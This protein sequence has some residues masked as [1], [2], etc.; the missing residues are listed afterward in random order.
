MSD[1]IILPV[2][3]PYAACPGRC[4][5]CNQSLSG[6]PTL[7]VSSDEIE[8]AVQTVLRSRT[9]QSKNVELAFY[10]GSFAGLPGAIRTQYLSSVTDLR[11]RGMIAG[12]RAS[13]RPDHIDDAIAAEFH[14]AGISLIE[15]G[16]PSLD[17]EVLSRTGRLHDAHAVTTALEACRRHGLS[18]G[19]QV[20]FG[21]PGDNRR[22]MA[23]TLEEIIHL[24]PDFVRIHPAIVFKNTVLA[25]MFHQGLYRPLNLPRAI[26]IAAEWLNRFDAAGIPVHRIGL[27]ETVSMQQPGCIVAGPH[28]PAFGS[29]VRELSVRKRIASKIKSY[30]A[31]TDSTGALDIIVPAHLLSQAIGHQKRNVMWLQARFTKIGSLRIISSAPDNTGMTGDP[32]IRVEPRTTPQKI[33]RRQRKASDPGRIERQ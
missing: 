17:D 2:F 27:Q 25:D 23:K 12:V 28:H 31:T 24:R 7:D 22:R 29:L 16:V 18:I 4:I 32:R 21:L 10:G 14:A 33:T 6:S 9:D 15:I 3:L 13:C 11:E 5:Y 19:F 26:L 20:M 1:T 8:T 30:L